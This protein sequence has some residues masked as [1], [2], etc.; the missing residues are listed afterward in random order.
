MRKVKREVMDKVVLSRTQNKAQ[1]CLFWVQP[2]QFSRQ[3][4]RFSYPQGKSK[5]LSKKHSCTVLNTL[6]HAYMG[7]ADLSGRTDLE[8]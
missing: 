8:A 3:K 2:T 4:R 6:S 5:P 1:N 7:D